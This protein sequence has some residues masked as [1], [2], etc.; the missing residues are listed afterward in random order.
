MLDD[1][2]INA[3]SRIIAS[4]AG[5]RL[6]NFEEIDISLNV[7]SAATFTTLEHSLLETSIVSSSYKKTHARS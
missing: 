6:H 5:N 4:Y 2:K 7:F 1:E 3:I